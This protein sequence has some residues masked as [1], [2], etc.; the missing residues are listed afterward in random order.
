M[1]GETKIELIKV[2][3]LSSFDIK[4]FMNPRPEAR[5]RHWSEAVEQIGCTTRVDELTGSFPIATSVIAWSVLETPGP[6]VVLTVS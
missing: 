5:T 1:H 6:S 4:A 3:K 2:Q